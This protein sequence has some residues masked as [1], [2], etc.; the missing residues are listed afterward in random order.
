MRLAFAL[1]FTRRIV[2]ADGVVREREAE[3]FDAVFPRDLVLRLGLDDASTQAEYFDAAR[4]ELPRTLGHHD[5]LGL[6]GLFFSACFSDGSLDA[7]EMRILK[8][9]GE[10]LG[11][12]REQVVKYLRRFW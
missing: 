11:L 8:D 7:R 4:V 6:V 9:A 12:T 5:K 10:A 1:Q 2:E 3:F